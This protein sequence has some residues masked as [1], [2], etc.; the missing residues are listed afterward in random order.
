MSMVRGQAAAVP[1]YLP[2]A[3]NY[4]MTVGDLASGALIT[5]DAAAN[6]DWIYVTLPSLDVSIGAGVARFRCGRA[7]GGLA[8]YP[9]EGGGLLQLGALTYL[10]S[11]YAQDV[12]CYLE[13][14]AAQVNEVRLSL[15]GTPLIP[16]TPGMSVLGETSG[17]TAA[18]VASIEGGNGL[19]VRGV[20]GV[21]QSG[22]DLTINSNTGAATTNAGP[23]SIPR[24]WVGQPLLGAWVDAD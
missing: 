22:E 19:L 12:A 3:E 10:Y 14:E 4:Q 11:A 13:F 8:I 18:V 24:R 2:L 16:V 17:A 5:D 7:G 1:G 6:N 21:F 15:D 20:V 23:V 9:Q